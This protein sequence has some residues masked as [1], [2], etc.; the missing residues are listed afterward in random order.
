[1]SQV[2]RGLVEVSCA[3]NVFFHI[4]DVRSAPSARRRRRAR[5]ASWWVASCNA[6]L[7][8]KP[9]KDRALLAEAKGE[10]EHIIEPS[11]PGS[12]ATVTTTSW[13]FFQVAFQRHRSV[14]GLTISSAN[15]Y[16]VTMSAQFADVCDLAPQVF[17]SRKQ[18][19]THELSG[20][21]VDH[22]AFVLHTT[23]LASPSALPILTSSR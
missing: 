2:P 16:V 20:T 5:S 4:R 18:A 10:H 19:M 15:F 13:F 8:A 9:P 11:L 7:G 6:A 21:G 12:D 23:S 14:A 22:K 3:P 1:M 17:K